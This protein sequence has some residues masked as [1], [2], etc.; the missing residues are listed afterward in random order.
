MNYWGDF[1][2]DEDT[3]QAADI[4]TQL[5]AYSSLENTEGDDESTPQAV[6]IN[7]QYISHSSPGSTSLL[8]DTGIVRN[9]QRVVKPRPKQ[10]YPCVF[11]GAKCEFITDEDG[12]K[13]CA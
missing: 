13:N 7:P 3:P 6:S 4:D 9:R 10:T 11:F 12:F 2:L 8:K 1:E 5:V